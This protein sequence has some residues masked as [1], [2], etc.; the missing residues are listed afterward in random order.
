MNAAYE[1][2]LNASYD[3]KQPISAIPV[4]EYFKVCNVENTKHTRKEEPPK[5]NRPETTDF[6]TGNTSLIVF[7]TNRVLTI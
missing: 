4:F 5:N 6:H 2:I 7:M 3:D 1:H